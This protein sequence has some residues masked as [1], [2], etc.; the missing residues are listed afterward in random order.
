[1]ATAL[2]YYLE[3]FRILSETV[4]VG[5]AAV[6]ANRCIN[7]AGAY[8]ASNGAYVAGVTEADAAAGANVSVMTMGIAVVEVGGAIPAVDTPLI[9]DTNGKVIA[10]SNLEIAAGGTA[11]TSTGANGASVLTGGV[12]PQQIVGW[13]KDTATGSGT[14]FIRV[15]LR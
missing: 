11:V 12:T 1:M 10:A 2:A 7:R 6:V 13:A 15:K 3:Q 4:K 9:A 5:N 8:P 14:E